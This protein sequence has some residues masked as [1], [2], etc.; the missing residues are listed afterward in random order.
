MT[1][2]SGPFSFWAF[3][4]LHRPMGRQLHATERGSS[5]RAGMLHVEVRTLLEDDR[6]ELGLEL[7]AGKK[8]LKRR[9]TVPWI[10]KPGLAFAGMT[11][12]LEPGRL[13]FISANEVHYLE[14]LPTPRARRFVRQF[15]ASGVSPLVLAQ[16]MEAPAVL[17]RECERAKVPLLRSTL[18]TPIFYDRIGRFLS[19]KLTASTSLHG[20]LMDVH[21]VGLLI[22]GK[23]G[24]GK[25]ECALDLVMRGHR[26]VADDV[27]G[28]KRKPPATCYGFGSE[29]I[30][31]HMEIRGLGIINIK[32]L[33]GVAAIRDEKVIELVIELATWDPA[34]PYDRLGIEEEKFTILGVELP[35]LRIPVSPG[36]NITSIIEVAARNQLLKIRGHHSAR[37][38][39]E[40]LDEELAR[41]TKAAEEEHNPSEE[42]FE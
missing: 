36:R 18:A 11:E 3:G 13:Q 17:L 28:V 22:V 39:R 29:L 32:D 7:L 35:L 1:I 12:H 19:D 42:G 23:S 37:E 34:R 41:Q 21:G 6:Y 4:P 14:G 31:Y 25:S 24:I 16:G 27:V 40:K 5:F 26:L 38:F 33:F 30:K 15:L 9:I 8:G 20:V 10:Q 2:P